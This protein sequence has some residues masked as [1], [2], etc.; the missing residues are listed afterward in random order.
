[1]VVRD[2]EIQPGDALA[3]EIEIQDASD[4]TSVPFHLTYDPG[5]L[6]FER[7]EEG[8]FLAGAGSTAF[9]AA[10]TTS[11]AEVVVGLSRLGR[12]PGARGDG[13]LCV[14]HFRAIGQGVAALGFAS[15]TVRDSAYGIVPSVFVPVQV[16]V[17]N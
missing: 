3:V 5:V 10:R 11:V 6:E 7:G 4:V 1:M 8:D 17:T 12:G 14:L 15:A 9:F 2:L 13:L 16:V